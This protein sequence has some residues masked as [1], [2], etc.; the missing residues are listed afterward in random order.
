MKYVLLYT[1]AEDV[2]AKAMAHYAAHRKRIDEFHAWGDL[3]LVG[4][5][6]DPQTQGSMGVFRT[7]DSAEEFVADDPFIRNGVIARYEI[8][9]WDEI[10]TP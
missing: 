9:E 3:L 7:R 4:A 10:L 1:S 5:F 2:M 8:R 6:G